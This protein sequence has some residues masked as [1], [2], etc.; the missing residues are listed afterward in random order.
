MRGFRSTLVL[1]V[2][3]AGL[4]AYIYFVESKKSESPSGEE[5]K[6][7][8]FALSADKINEISVKNSSADPTVVKKVDGAWQIVQPVQAAADQSEVQNVT[9]NLATAEVQ[10][11]VDENPRDLKQF[12]LAEPRIDIGFKTAADK[13]FRHLLLGDKTPTQA[14]IYAKLPTEKK[15]FLVPVFLESGFNRS[16]FDLRDKSVLKFDRNKVDALALTSGDKTVQLAKAGED[17]SIAKPIQARADYGT[18]EG[19]IGRL[20]SAQMKSLVVPEAKD[21]KE[22]GLDKPEVTATIGAGSAQATLQVGKKAAD[23]NM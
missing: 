7:K 20:Q 12:G 8:V 15:V 18:V 10:R 11:V 6:P 2:V 16:T 5:A 17:W 4:V 1:L 21:L 23:G 9:S 22:Y 13:D 14:D 3:F 19:L